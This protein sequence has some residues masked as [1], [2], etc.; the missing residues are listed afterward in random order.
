MRPLPSFRQLLVL[1]AIGCVLPI[2]GLSVG[3]IAYEY[4]R[5][6]HE[7]E[8]NAIGTARGLMAGVDDRF[9]SV[10]HLL[11]GLA[12]SPALMT[13][14][15]GKL[16]EEAQ[17]VSRSE[18]VHG[19]VLVGSDG[20]SVFNTRIPVGEPVPLETGVRQIDMARDRGITVLDVFRSPSTGEYVS[21]VAMAVPGN[22]L[23][24]VS[25]D[26]A[27]LREVLVRQKLPPTW[28][29]AVLDRSGRIVART[30][31]NERFVGTPARA[32][33]V[34]TIGQVQEAAVESV[35][36][37]GV[38]VVSAFSRSPVS[39]W[40]VVLGVPRTELEAPLLQSSLLLAGGTAVV[41]LLTLWLAVRL[42]R[43]LSASVE[44]LGG[45]TRAA[46]HNALLHLPQ[47]VFQE[48]HQ[49]GQALLLANAAVD[50]A[51]EA[52]KRLEHRMHSVLD[53]A[54]DG[55]V[56]ADGDGRIVLF[57]RAA[58]AMFRLPQEDAIGMELE[59][60]LPAEQRARHRQLRAQLT[61]EHARRMAPGRRV[62]GLRADG[63]TFL[64]EA[65]ISVTGE[66]D[67][68]LYTAILRPVPTIA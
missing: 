56:T 11:R 4:Q 30:H 58:E 3:V 68:V 44:A 65:S 17:L 37:D 63:T 64:A 8:L 7:L 5:E 38:P 49:L 27:W 31:E 23:L 22:R 52:Q 34:A 19:V 13:E 41:M 50:D 18:H 57:N 29:A 26:P 35:T 42:A 28:I 10:G 55:I 48:A 43:R 6:R 51:H 2:A 21:G 62:E 12:N 67:D 40:S 53:T 39:G 66:G 20:Q 1:L 33:L 46:S 36:V 61:L 25:I 16:A 54:M 59:M 47:P 15:V 32:A 14:D 45:A 24:Q 9:E 60:L